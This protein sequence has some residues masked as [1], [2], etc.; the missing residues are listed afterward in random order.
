MLASCLRRVYFFLV[1]QVLESPPPKPLSF[2]RIST[3]TPL[4]IG[5]ILIAFFLSGCSEE[6]PVAGDHTISQVT[7]QVTMPSGEAW[8][9]HY[10]GPRS[11]ATHFAVV[12]AKHAARLFGETGVEPY[13]RI[14]VG[15]YHQIE[16]GTRVEEVPSSQ[17]G[18]LEVGIVLSQITSHIASEPEIRSLD[19]EP[20]FADKVLDV[21]CNVSYE[22]GGCSGGPFGCVA[23]WSCSNG[24]SGCFG[25]DPILC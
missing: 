21:D 18:H 20:V 10:E 16:V 24:S 12:V 14:Q 2:M 1:Y 25:I 5:V 9:Q 4:A 7:I 3:Y 19:K 13:V 8:S 23:K 6:T 22:V 11:E 17:E 15:D